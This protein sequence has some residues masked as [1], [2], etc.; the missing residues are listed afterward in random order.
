MSLGDVGSAT[1]T[2]LGHHRVLHLDPLAHFYL[3]DHR[4]SRL[5]ARQTVVLQCGRRDVG[6]TAV[7]PQQCLV[8]V[9]GGSAV[10]ARGHRA[11]RLAFRT[12]ALEQPPWPEALAQVLPL[13]V[14]RARRPAPEVLLDLPAQ[15]TGYPGSEPPAVRKREV[16]GVQLSDLCRHLAD[17]HQSAS[18]IPPAQHT[19]DKNSAL[20][21]LHI[22]IIVIIGIQ[23]QQ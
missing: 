1:A 16:F 19:D 6:L 4:R 2:A 20:V 5:R 3:V 17:G 12:V 13:S 22:V 7:P 21:L 23:V 15:L 18:S 10:H 9:S 11:R 8:L 14:H